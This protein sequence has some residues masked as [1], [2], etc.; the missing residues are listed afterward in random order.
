MVS[1]KNQP[2]ARLRIERALGL[3]LRAERA[4]AARVTTLSRHGTRFEYSGSVTREP[5]SRSENYGLSPLLP[6]CLDHGRFNLIG[7]S[8][9][10]RSQ[11][12]E[13]FS[14]L[15]VGSKIADQPSF[16]C[17]RPELSESGLIV[18]PAAKR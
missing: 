5:C 14:L 4:V 16:G 6:A 15:R 7:E 12:G 17:F 11:I 10:V 13:C 1:H 9:E 2:H 8:R 3:V 18:L